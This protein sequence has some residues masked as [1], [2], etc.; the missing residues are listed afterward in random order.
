MN[1]N[2]LPYL[3]HFEIEKCNLNKDQL[4]YFK[5]KYKFDVPSDFIKFLSEVGNMTM[6]QSK[7]YL[8]MP[9]FDGLYGEH[10]DGI[11]DF[12]LTEFVLKSYLDEEPY[13]LIILIDK[14]FPVGSFCFAGQRNLFMGYGE[15]NYNKIYVYDYELCKKPIYV[16]HNIETFFKDVLYVDDFI[17]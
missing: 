2:E 11:R 16:T 7:Q 13:R 15:D 5:S 17:T 3:S 8:L 4:K 1:F 9:N 12:A 10:F 6:N 14:L